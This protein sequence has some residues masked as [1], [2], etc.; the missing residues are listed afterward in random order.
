[1]HPACSESIPDGDIRA[2]T[3][4]E[5]YQKYKRFREL[6]ELNSQATCRWCPKPDCET[7]VIANPDDP[8]FPCISCTKCSF[9]FCYDCSCDWHPNLTCKENAK[10]NK[11]SKDKKSEKWRKSHKV[12][13]CDQCGM[14]I[15][16]DSGCNH[17]K[18][19]R[20]GY[21]F[22]WICMNQFTPDHYI[23][24]TCAGLQFTAHPIAKKRLKKLRNIVVGAVVIIIAV[25]IVLVIA[26]IG[27][28]VLLIAIP[29]YAVY[30]FIKYLKMK[31]KLRKMKTKRNNT[32]TTLP[33]SLPL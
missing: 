12:R 27:I 2:L 26:G 22:C 3:D 7:A 30:R 24:S 1:M 15:Q 16:K 18:C 9:Q 4:D 17:M 21:E 28:I 31:W 25:P 8:E 29:C 11:S 5:D 6:T 10:L 13:K 33:D 20:C 32:K 19:T 23:N 14:D